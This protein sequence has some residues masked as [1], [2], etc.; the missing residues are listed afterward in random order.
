MKKAKFFKAVI[1]DENSHIMGSMICIITQKANNI[2]IVDNLAKCYAQDFFGL[3]D[4]L[5][6]QTL[7]DELKNNGFCLL[8]LPNE[9]NCEM[10]ALKGAIEK[11]LNIP[12][13][14]TIREF[15]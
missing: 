2:P 11:A 3:F 14:V 6:D 8:P 5:T 1:K 9:A 12:V 15:E 13:K 4:N 10:D 7:S